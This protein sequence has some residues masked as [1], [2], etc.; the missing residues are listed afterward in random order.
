MA[1]MTLTCETMSALGISDAD[2]TTPQLGGR[3]KQLLEPLLAS[4][5][6]DMSRGI[7]VIRLAV[8]GYILE[9]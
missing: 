4:S 9:Q 5:G 8:M 6:F 2:L 3:A 1:T 7:R